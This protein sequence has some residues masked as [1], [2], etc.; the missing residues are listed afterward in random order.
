MEIGKKQ[1]MPKGHAGKLRAA[2]YLQN[3]GLERFSDNLKVRAAWE[4]LKRGGEEGRKEA[5]E[6]FVTLS[7]K[8]ANECASNFLFIGFNS[9]MGAFN[10]D[11]KFDFAIDAIKLSIEIYERLGNHNPELIARL[12]LAEIYE[13]KAKKV[14]DALYAHKSVKASHI[15]MASIDCGNAL[16]VLEELSAAREKYKI[17]PSAKELSEESLFKQQL[18]LKE[19]LL[20]SSYS[21]S[22]ST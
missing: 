21:K 10:H 12:R 9:A 18:K 5:L 19:K 15:V 16:K 14:Y 3:I 20:S 2:K 22:N 17:K 8:K 7:K 11:G 1:E 6:I 13:L 4:C